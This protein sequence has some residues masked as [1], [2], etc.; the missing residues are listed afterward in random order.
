MGLFLVFENWI[1]LSGHLLRRSGDLAWYASQHT[2]SPNQ[3]RSP[4]ERRSGR[5]LGY[6]ERCIVTGFGMNFASRQS[7]RERGLHCKNA[8]YETSQPPCAGSTLT[9]PGPCLPGDAMAELL[10]LL[11]APTISCS[12]IEW[13]CQA[14]GMPLD[15]LHTEIRGAVCEEKNWQK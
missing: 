7:F 14:A 4:S 1:R 6:F 3:P 12:P 2:C 10:T 15:P 13:N 5:L 11:A 8:R 9:T